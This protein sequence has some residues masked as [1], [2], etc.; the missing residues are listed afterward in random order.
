MAKIEQH[1]ARE[2][3]IWT[4]V[5]DIGAGVD[6]WYLPIPQ[7]G[8][9]VRAYYVSDTAQATGNAELEFT[10]G[11]TALVPVIT[12]P[13]AAGAVGRSHVAIFSPVAGDNFVRE[14]DDLDLLAAGAMLSVATDGG[15]AGTGRICVVIRP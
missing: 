9:V 12:V 1:D 8:T 13:S 2:Y 10:I 5:L 4:E 3:H 11:T 7:A 14:P 15:G 6:T